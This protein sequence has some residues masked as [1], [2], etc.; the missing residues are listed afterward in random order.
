MHI[1]VSLLL[2]MSNICR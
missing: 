2:F 1:S